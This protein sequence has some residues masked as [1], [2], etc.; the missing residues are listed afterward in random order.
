MDI[1]EL[2]FELRVLQDGL[3]TDTWI[4]VTSGRLKEALI[5][6]SRGAVET[7]YRSGKYW[8][9]WRG[10]D[11]TAEDKSIPTRPIVLPVRV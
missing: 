5:R 7:A 6:K 4:K 10:I 8:Y 3:P 2:A 1:D 11:R 9:V